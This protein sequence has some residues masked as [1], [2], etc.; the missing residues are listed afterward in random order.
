MTEATT[1]TF[2]DFVVLSVPTGRWRQ[3]CYLVHHSPTRRQLLIDPGADAAVLEAMVLTHGTFLDHMLLT[4]AHYDHVGAAAAMSRRFGLSCQIHKADKR[5]LLHAPMYAGRFEKKK[6][7]PVKNFV[8]FEQ[9]PEFE[10]GGQVITA[11]TCPGHTSGGMVY[12]L[13]EFV[14]TGDSLLYEKVGRTDLPGG[15]DAQLCRS[16]V[17]LL[18]YYPA[19]FTI[20]TGHGRPWRVSEARIWWKKVDGMPPKFDMWSMQP[21]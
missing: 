5:L 9:P 3:N 19:E 12:S 4:H 11:L 16:V 7:E 6:L 14:F 20:F 10:F 2:G 13:G 21:E 1:Q 18:D 15:D 17:R 8:T